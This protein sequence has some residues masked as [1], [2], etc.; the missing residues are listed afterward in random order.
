MTGLLIINA[1]DFGG[2]RL[3][4]DR[5]AEC[6]AAGSVTSTSAMVYMNDSERAA[7]IARSRELPVGLHLNVTQAFEDPATPPEVRERQVSLVRYFASR[8]LRRFTFNPAVSARARRCVEDQLERF[9]ELFGREPSHIDGHN[10][11]HLSPTVL[12]TLPKGM[13]VRTGLTGESSSLRALPGRSRHAL[14]SRRQLTTDYFLAIDRLGASP[15]EQRIEQL[16]APAEHAR[17]EVMVHPDRDY[18]FAIL[19]SDAWKRALAQRRLGSF[20]QL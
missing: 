18:D 16:F 9:R 12:L 10:H 8:R 17:V 6:F 11:G 1:D 4:T 7:E 2:N 15:R 20:E 13:R 14:I 3:A 5:I 19:M